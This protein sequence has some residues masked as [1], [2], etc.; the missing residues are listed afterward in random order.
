MTKPQDSVNSPAADAEIAA[1]IIYFVKFSNGLSCSQRAFLLQ[2]HLVSSNGMPT[3]LLMKYLV[4]MCKD[5][6]TGDG[7]DTRYQM[8]LLR[9][10]PHMFEVMC[11][12]NS[13]GEAVDT[14]N[15]P[16]VPA[17]VNN[18]FTEYFEMYTA[19]LQLSRSSDDEQD[20][21]TFALRIKNVIEIF[22]R[23]ANLVASGSTIRETSERSVIMRDNNF[24]NIVVE[25]INS[26]VDLRRKLANRTLECTPID[27]RG[28]I[29]PYVMQYTTANSTNSD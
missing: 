15:V 12:W 27:E 7:T 5:M 8:E 28:N 24:H 23:I 14:V 3:V 19:A 6:S 11:F 26:F 29:A 10:N 16:D 17:S 18:A 21:Q 20:V 22:M 9:R 1:A 2:S 25:M 13:F 4:A